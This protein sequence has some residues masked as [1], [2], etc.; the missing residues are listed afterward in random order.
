MTEED[1]QENFNQYRGLFAW[2]IK[3]NRIAYGR[4]LAEGIAAYPEQ[5]AIAKDRALFLG[6][7]GCLQVWIPLILVPV[8][9]IVAGHTLTGSASII[10]LTI[11]YVW[12]AAQ[13]GI[14]LQRA[15]LSYLRN[16]RWKRYNVRLYKSDWTN[17]GDLNDI[18]S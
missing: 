13:S 9:V 8:P 7:R 11:G 4:Y 2:E 10:T 1:S 15:A 5:P 16:P 6:W 17:H 14:A 12:F 3:R 18:V